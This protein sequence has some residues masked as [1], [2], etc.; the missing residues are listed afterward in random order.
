MPET[1]FQLPRLGD[2][3]GT[4]Y[5]INLA[6]TPGAS[7]LVSG[8]T[9]KPQ[10]N[11]APDARGHV[12]MSGFSTDVPGLK[13]I[14]RFGAANL[15]E[16]PNVPPKYFSPA[17]TRPATSDAQ[18]LQLLAQ[19]SSNV[20]QTSLLDTAASP[21]TGTPGIV[22]VLRDDATDVHVDVTRQQ[23]GWL[24]SDLA[25]YPGW[26]A[27]VNGRTVPISRANVA[28]SA[29]PVGR[30]V[31]H[32]VFTYRSTSVLVSSIISLLSLVVVVLVV[33]VPTATKPLRSRG[34]RSGNP[35]PGMAARNH[36]TESS[37]D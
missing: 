9:V 21:T 37:V 14:G 1:S 13:L 15:F 5:R 4:S 29:V 11:G 22:R 20:Y 25:Y 27:S 31:S 17:Q 28:F 8:D 24:I 3:G 19:D 26:R 7:L 2:N 35:L 30:G 34:H 12:V 10:L 33:A 32:V 6:G 16:V 18:A 36:P 23:P